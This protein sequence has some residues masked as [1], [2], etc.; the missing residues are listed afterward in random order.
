M[1]L[2]KLYWF[3]K[4]VEAGSMTKAAKYGGCAVSSVSDNIR[5][6]EAALRVRLLERSTRRLRLTEAGEAFYERARL[7]VA[8]AE[9]AWA[10]VDAWHGEPAGV[11]TVSV[12][13]E[14][15]RGVM[16]PVLKTIGMRYPK[17]NMRL[18]L[19]TG[20]SDLLRE[21]IDLAIRVG[22]LDD[23]RLVARKLMEMSLHAVAT[24]TFLSSHS[25]IRHPRDLEHAPCV[26]ILSLV[27][28]KVW[29][30]QFTKNG[31]TVPVV[32]RG[33]AEVSSV[34]L[35]LDMALADMGIAL[36]SNLLLDKSHRGKL[37]FVLPDWRL[38]KMP[39]WAVYP[40]S[41][42]LPQKVRVFVDVVRHIL[43]QIPTPVGDEN[44]GSPQGGQAKRN[45][46][47]GL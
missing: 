17:L 45:P 38:P 4:V 35:G 30:W 20:R 32:P 27:S 22:E 46:P 23:S 1:E 13:P 21:N 9:T 16:L 24:E 26:P 47:E 14:L 3:V 39:V 19:T 44:G 11:L 29:P 43:E 10:A 15:A 6:L 36:V 7:A 8:S 40:S 2:D 25:P 42:H 18:L 33:R 37:S 28:N 5:R 34:G 31:E 41:S 12:A